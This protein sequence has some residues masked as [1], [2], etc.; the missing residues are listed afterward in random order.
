[1]RI[2]II[3]AGP[4]G[5]GAAHRLN[6]LGFDNFLVCDRNPYVGGLAASWKDAEGF[7]WDFAVHVAH[8]H[9]TYVDRVMDELLPDGF[10]THIRKSWVRE[11]GV[12]IPYPFQYN[13]RHLPPA[14]RD[15]C[16]RGLT[17]LQ[18]PA[19]RPT[20]KN[21]REHIFATFGDGIAKHFMIPYNRKN[22]ATDPA[23]MNCRWIG[24][25][26]P[27][28]DVPRVLRNIEQ[29]V[30]DVSWGP[31]STFQ[32]PK[33]GGTGAIWEAMAARL[34]PGHLRLSTALTGL[35]PKAKVARFS[36]GSAEPYDFLVSTIPVTILTRLAGLD[37]LA[38]RAAGLRHTQV[39]VIGLAPRFR[40][41]DSLGDK[42]WL[43]CPEDACAFYRVTP[44]SLFSPAHVPDVEKHCSFLV[45]ISQPGHEAPMKGD[46]AKLTAD[47]MKAIGLLDA[48]VR[49]GH[50]RLMY[51]DHGY[52]IPTLDRDD[53]LADVLPELE[54]MNILSRGRFG[55]WKYEVGN[56]DHCLMQ[57]VEAAERIL[58]GTPEIT[59][60]EPNKVNAGKR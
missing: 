14:V 7:T 23:E 38:S 2:L 13:I 60:A 44:F 12:F 57:G 31:N 54:S 16:V 10:L 19:E 50:V 17:A 29:G 9:Y 49:D 33:T 1:M 56:M 32:F 18:P 47:G 42:T 48:N 39:H 15:E 6:E 35:D 41:P 40:L 36:D 45:E 28:I 30:D 21:F 11:Y 8:S 52:P 22:W 34:K 55:G 43:Y 25:R 46:L 5:L 4:C 53:I 26:V 37:A 20:A 24:D 27:A 51:A 3:G 58:N 59:L